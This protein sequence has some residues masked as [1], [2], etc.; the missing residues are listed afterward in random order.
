MKTKT[1]LVI[2]L[3]E[4]EFFQLLAS[5]KII[6]HEKYGIGFICL[7]YTMEEGDIIQITLE[8]KP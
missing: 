1:N 7:S 5:K 8:K 2:T 4:E 6:S 3:T